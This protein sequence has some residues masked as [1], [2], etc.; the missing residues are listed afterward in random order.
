MVGPA[1]LAGTVWFLFVGS[2][3]LLHLGFRVASVGLES[4]LRYDLCVHRIHRSRRAPLLAR[5]SASG[6]WTARVFATVFVS[7]L[8]AAGLGL[9]GYYVWNFTQGNWV[10]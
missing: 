9:Q 10:A 7:L 6:R 2:H 8:F 4:M 5:L 3:H 1:G